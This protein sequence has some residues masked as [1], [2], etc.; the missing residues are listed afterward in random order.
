M[1]LW[2]KIA[3]TAGVI[4][5]LAFLA[6][7]AFTFFLLALIGGVVLFVLNLFRKPAT[8]MPYNSPPVKTYHPSRHDDDIIDI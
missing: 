5:T 2:M 6:I 1:P 4:T 7:F 8:Q 3:L